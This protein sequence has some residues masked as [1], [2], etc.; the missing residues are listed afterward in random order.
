[1]TAENDDHAGPSTQRRLASSS[2][3]GFRSRRAFCSLVRRHLVLEVGV[4]S[5]RMSRGKDLET[6]EDDA[7]EIRLRMDH[8]DADKQREA[9]ELRQFFNG[10]YTS[11]EHGRTVIRHVDGIKQEKTLPDRRDAVDRLL[12]RKRK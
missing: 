5:E 6:Y 8:W 7:R 3:I 10:L 11:E 12:G 2:R 9:R 1:M 4:V